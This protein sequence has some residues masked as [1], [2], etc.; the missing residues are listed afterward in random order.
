LFQTEKVSRYRLVAGKLVTTANDPRRDNEFLAM[1]QADGQWTSLSQPVSQ[2]HVYDI[3][4]GRTAGEL[5][6]CGSA[7]GPT[8][9]RAQVWRSTDGG[10]TWRQAFDPGPIILAAVDQAYAGRFYHIAYLAGKVFTQ[11]FYDK[12]SWVHQGGDD[13]DWIPGPNLN[14]FQ[15]PVLFDGKL[16]YGD[17]TPDVNDSLVTKDVPTTGVLRTLDSLGLI[18]TIATDVQCGRASELYIEENG[19]CVGDD[20]RLYVLGNDRKLYATSRLTEPFVVVGDAP[21]AV[22]LYSLAVLAGSAYFGGGG[23]E[24]YRV[25]LY[26]E[27]HSKMVTQ[28][29]YDG[30]TA[31]QEQKAVHLSAVLTDAAGAPVPGASVVFTFDGQRLPATTDGAG[32][33]STETRFPRGQDRSAPVTVDYAGDDTYEQSRTTASVDRKE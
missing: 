25:R 1:Q 22:P 6:A 20:G 10:T 13:R 29:T 2:L 11:L 9:Q 27:Q 12:Y 15:Y 28:L 16:V 8:Y 18:E 7:S 19:H 4:Q 3:C 14:C 31:A 33:A 17:R 21:A 26:R 5:W 30:D 32:R 23:A 24:I